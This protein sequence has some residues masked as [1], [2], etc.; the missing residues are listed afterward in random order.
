MAGRTDEELLKILMS[1]LGDYQPAA[2]QAAKKEFEGRGLPAPKVEIIQK[3]ILDEQT[4]IIAKA[5]EPLDTIWKV[6]SFLLPGII[7]LIVSRSFGADGFERKSN[8]IVNWTLYGFGFY[9]V[10]TLLLSC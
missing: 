10:T 6:L 3:E 4:I 2:L 9:I 5:E 1:P 7:P 8:E